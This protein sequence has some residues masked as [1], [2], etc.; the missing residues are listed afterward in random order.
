MRFL[1]DTNIVSE[2]RRRIRNPRLS[3]WIESVAPDDLW[4]SALTLGEI[5]KGME[6]VSRRDTAAAAALGRWFDHLRAAFAQRTIGIDGAIAET[7]GRLAAIR[8]RPVV[9]G[10]LAATAITHEVTLV[11]RNARDFE[12]LGVGL[13][14]PWSMP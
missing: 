11:T 1:L 5:V 10:L 12:G 14:D 6:M 8:P 13:L 3:H 4:I 2:M 7:W 9:D